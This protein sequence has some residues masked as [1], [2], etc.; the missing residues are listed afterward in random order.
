[1]LKWLAIQVSAGDKV[2]SWF[3]LNADTVKLSLHSS[4]FSAT[5]INTVVI[6]I[7]IVPFSGTERSR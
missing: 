2:Q 4:R 5:H 6:A 3:C 7:V 1:M